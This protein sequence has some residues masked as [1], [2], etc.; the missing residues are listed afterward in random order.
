MGRLEPSQAFT[1]PQYNTSY[2]LLCLLYAICHQPLCLTVAE[3]ATTDDWVLQEHCG[4][5]AQLHFTM[6]A[7]QQYLCRSR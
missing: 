4:E 1:A 3:S 2:H 5:A 6:D 7:S